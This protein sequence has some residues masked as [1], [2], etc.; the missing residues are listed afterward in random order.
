[1]W[2]FFNFGLLMPALVPAK[3]KNRPDVLKW[4]NDGEYDLQVR[5]RLREHLQYFMDNYMP[6][7]TFN[8][9]IQATPDKDYN[10]RFYTTVE[11]YAEGIKQAALQMDYEKFKVTSE[12]FEWNK[13]YHTI[14]NS[15]WAVVCRLNEPGGFYGPRSAENP[16]GYTSR[17]TYGGSDDAGW[18]EKRHNTVGRRIGDTF[19][20]PD[21]EWKRHEDER[22]MI[23]FGDQKYW[24]EDSTDEEEHI[25]IAP[26]GEIF[27]VDADTDIILEELDGSDIPMSSWWSYTTP[28]EF[29]RLTPVLKKHF[30][31]KVLRSMRKKNLKRHAEV[32]A[33]YTRDIS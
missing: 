14:L 10:F 9:E 29:N 7:G 20:I 15:I 25:Y 18:Y 33:G 12:R 32:H 26:D 8:P 13:K 3:V 4:T 30:G 28:A 16:R 23:D 2:A 1:M 19:G 5:G 6:E 21:E 27:S 11:A 24:W 17:G 31:K 22:P